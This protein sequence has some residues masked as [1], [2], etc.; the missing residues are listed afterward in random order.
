[1]PNKTYNDP[2]KANRMGHDTYNR[3][4]QYLQVTTGQA[5]PDHWDQ[6][7]E[8][9]DQFNRARTAHEKRKILSCR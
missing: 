4:R 1:V 6:I 2:E 3:I 8:Q 5:V 7:R 9:V